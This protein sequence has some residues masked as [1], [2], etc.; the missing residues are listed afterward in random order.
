[1]P[2][3][4]IEFCSPR[5][6]PCADD[7]SFL[8][9]GPREIFIRVGKADRAGRQVKLGRTCKARWNTACEIC[10][11]VCVCASTGVGWQAHMH[12]APGAQIPGTQIH[13]K[14]CLDRADKRARWR[15]RKLID[16]EYI[17]SITRFPLSYCDKPNST[18]D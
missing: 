11:C 8:V 18:I 10:A 1:M 9:R 13:F 3:S 15:V 17:I 6:S 16:Y 12:T 5:G 2:N 4:A 14:N 7:L